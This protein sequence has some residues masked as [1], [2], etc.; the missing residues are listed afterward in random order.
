MPGGV[1]KGET[2]AVR[3]MSQGNWR[4]GLSCSGAQRPGDAQPRFINAGKWVTGQISLP[5]GTLFPNNAY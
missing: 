5:V 3:A 2:A 1:T 4:Q